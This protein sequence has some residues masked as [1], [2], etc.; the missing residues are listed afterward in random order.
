MILSLRG[1]EWYRWSEG[2][3]GEEEKKRRK[4]KQER[5]GGKVGSDHGKHNESITSLNCSCY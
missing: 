3:S 1:I 2:R 4:R 5:G